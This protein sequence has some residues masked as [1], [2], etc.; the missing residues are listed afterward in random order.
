MH[1]PFLTDRDGSNVAARSL[2]LFRKP[3]CQQESESYYKKIGNGKC[4][5][6]RAYAAF[7]TSKKHRNPNFDA[8]QPAKLGVQGKGRVGV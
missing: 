7:P 5:R 4:Q 6:A 8:A 3:R 1:N 2:F